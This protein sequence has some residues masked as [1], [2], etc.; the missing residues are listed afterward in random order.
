MGGG[1]WTGPHP[2]R[3][4]SQGLSTLATN[5]PLGTSSTTTSELD[6][7]KRSAS[8]IDQVVETDKFNK[9]NDSYCPTLAVVFAPRPIY[10][11]RVSICPSLRNMMPVKTVMEYGT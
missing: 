6:C 8:E 3:S 10:R 4:P 1:S 2:V 7:T 9:N 5:R 11:V